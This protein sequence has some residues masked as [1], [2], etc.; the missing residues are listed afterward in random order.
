[1]FSNAM[2]CN[3]TPKLMLDIDDIQ[4]FS[5]DAH[6][7]NYFNGDLV[8]NLTGISNLPSALNIPELAEHI[9]IGFDEVMVPW[10]D[11]GLPRVHISFWEALHTYVQSKEYKSVCIHC[12]GGHG[13]TGTALCAVL[14]AICG[15]S[16]EESVWRV[17]TNH[18]E[19]AVETTSQCRYLQLI[20]L[21]YNSRAPNNET[22]PVSSMEIQAADERARLAKENAKGKR[23]RRKANKQQG[24]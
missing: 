20:D 11:F 18:C 21:H 7:I 22:C 10:P 5:S 3:H 16:A 13:R 19:K 6:G 23:T 4:Y 17:R 12:H 1:M 14:I 24:S 2:A 15:Y 9:D 8:I